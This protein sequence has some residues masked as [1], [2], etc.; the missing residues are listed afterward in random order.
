MLYFVGY[1][2]LA[3]ALAKGFWKHL[4]PGQEVIFML[5]WPLWL[6]AEAYMAAMDSW[7]GRR[8]RRP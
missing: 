1:V 4:T 2:V 5:L 7:G 3:I 8:F 6:L